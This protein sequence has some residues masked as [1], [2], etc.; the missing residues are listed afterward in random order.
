MHVYNEIH[1]LLSTLTIELIYIYIFTSYTAI[2]LIV[3]YDINI[4][5]SVVLTH[6]G[7]ASIY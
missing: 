2:N 5:I 4:Y 3:V 1:V 7:M 6:N